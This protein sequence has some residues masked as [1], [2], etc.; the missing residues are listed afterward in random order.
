[1]I[2]AFGLKY[3]A[4]VA[5]NFTAWSVFYCFWVSNV[6]LPII[7]LPIVVYKCFFGGLQFWKIFTCL[8]A[9]LSWAAA[10][11]VAS[12]AAG[13]YQWTWFNWSIN[14]TSH[15]FAFWVA[16]LLILHQFIGPER[17]TPIAEMRRMWSK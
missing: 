8:I 5:F 2:G 17:S 12:F 1:M 7:A 11:F 4:L 15:T 16:T 14:H 10:L 13:Y 3:A 9:P 6:F